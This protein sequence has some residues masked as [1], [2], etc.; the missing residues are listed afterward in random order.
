[1]TDHA[2]TSGTEIPPLRLEPTLRD[3][4]RYA[5][6]S[7]DFYEMHYDLEFARRLG[8]PELSLHG[9]FKTA[10]LGRLVTEWIG[11][12]GRLTSLSVRY[13]RMDYRNT[14]LTCKALVEST[15]GG[16]MDLR[17]W[18]ENADGEATTT[19]HAAI[20]LNA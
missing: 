19:G 13:R 11:G 3:I 5:G 7:G 20:T 17:I 10:L 2:I 14:P 1:M 16:R 8:H 18:T 4:V 9:L 12:H 15:G 6:A